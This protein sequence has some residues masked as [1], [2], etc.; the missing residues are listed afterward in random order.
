MAKKKETKP[1]SKTSAP[2]PKTSAKQKPKTSKPKQTSTAKLKQKTSEKKTMSKIETKDL[3]IR[4]FITRAEALLEDFNEDM[5]ITS[6]LTGQE[7]KRL[8]S[9]R[10][11]NN[12]FIDKAF[13]IAKD[14]P[15]FLP[16]HFDSAVLNWKMGNFQDLRQLMA[17]VES[18]QHSIMDAFIIQADDCFKDALR[19]YGSLREQTRGRVP[20]AAALFDLLEIYFKRRTRAGD[21]PTEKQ[22]EK[23]IHGLIHG[24][25]DGEIVIRNE[26][27]RTTR[28]VHEVIDSVRTGRKALKETIEESRKS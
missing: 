13:D 22:L 7:R 21:E 15:E 11:R 14:N 8:T 3:I 2:K 28:G 9:A 4:G 27:P 24:T 20:G 19:I 6:N 12:G 16:P 1:K 18:L 26:S 25:K 10:V 17:V 23:D 5:E